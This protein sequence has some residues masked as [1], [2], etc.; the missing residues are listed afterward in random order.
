MTNTWLTR[1][2]AGHLVGG[3]MTVL[4]A[5]N[6]TTSPTDNPDPDPDPTPANTAPVARAGADQTVSAT[7]VTSLDGSASSDADG[8]PI[9]YAWSLASQPAGS[10]A[11]L[12]DATAATPTFTPDAAG[13]YVLRLVVSD[14]TDTS[15]PDEVTVTAENNTAMATIGSTGGTVS[16]VDGKVVLDVPA[17]ALSADQEISITMVTAGQRGEDLADV[18]ADALVYEMRPDGLQFDMPVQVEIMP[19]PEFSPTTTDDES[20]IPMLTMVTLSGGMVELAAGQTIDIDVD[21]GTMS[22]VGS[23]EHFSTLV[24]IPEV[25][26]GGEIEEFRLLAQVPTTALLGE[27][28]NVPVVFLPNSP[29][30]FVGVS[31][32]YADASDSPVDLNAPLNAEFAP[33][34]G[35]FTRGFFV[36]NE[37]VCTAR[38]PGTWGAEI[39]IEGVAP[40]LPG[41][42]SFDNENP[43]VIQASRGISCFGGFDSFQLP[44]PEGIVR[45]NGRTPG[46]GL[47]SGAGYGVTHGTLDMGGDGSGRLVFA[48]QGGALLT[49]GDGLPIADFD[50]PGLAGQSV[51]GA[52][53]LGA[54]GM[55]VNSSVG[56]FVSTGPLL[57]TEQDPPTAV[58]LSPVPQPVTGPDMAANATDLISFGSD[59]GGFGAVAVLFG[60]QDIAFFAAGTDV[61]GGPGFAFR[62]DLAEAF[63]PGGVSV[64]GTELP[65]TAWVGEQGFSETSPMLVGTVTDDV[66]RNST[67]W[68]VELVGGVAVPVAVDNIFPAAEV[69]RIR[70]LEGICA[71]TAYG[72]GFGFGNTVMFTWDGADGVEPIQGLSGRT[73]G[74]DLRMSGG[75]TVLI[76]TTSFTGNS[77]VVHEISTAGEYL[78]GAFEDAP[79]GCTGPGH[80]AFRQDRE[81]ILT[82]NSSGEAVS[83]T[84]EFPPS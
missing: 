56:L 4:I 39:T 18:S 74:V 57:E 31:G 72:S 24:L 42:D 70:C 78:N 47:A 44:A 77:F 33:I 80:V 15:V 35:P 52:A 53:A 10:T 59:E 58:S 8:D 20:T 66:D 36:E 48:R 17:G 5:A 69:R 54:D 2:T 11:S 71:V 40:V 45:V 13:T 68:I 79:A 63:K 43:L 62:E 34:D 82:C 9:T 83:A 27:P 81:V 1:R 28:F 75:N 6:C 7:L 46:V 23:I 26:V 60:D 3:L 22:L 65:V 67:L 21:A 37:Y 73:I 41:I 51:Y 61:G 30:S 49:T 76:A 32:L 55:M 64:F 50:A 19:S 12:V 14:G 38:G 84:F 16:S 29:A 25:Q